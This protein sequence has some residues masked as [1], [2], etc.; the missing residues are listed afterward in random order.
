[1]AHDTPAA[2]ARADRTRALTATRVDR[3]RALTAA[4]LLLGAGAV[5]APAAAQTDYYNLDR[6]RPARIEDAYATERYAF[7]LKVATLRL[8]REAGGVYHWGYEPE[9][10]YGILPRTSVEVGLPFAVIDA[11]A[12][13]R[14]SGLAGLELSVLYNLNAETQGLPALGLR[15]DVLLPVGSLAPDRA[16][17]A[18][19]G[20]MTRSFRWARFHV[21]AQYTFGAA[22]EPAAAPPPD[23]LHGP[24]EEPPRWLAGVAVDHV[25]P[26]RALLLIADVYASQPLHQD[27]A[28]AWDAGVGLRYQVN[29]YLAVDAGLGRRLTGAPAW[30]LTLGSAFAFGLRPFVPVPR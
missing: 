23:G 3:T 10:A 9:L 12:A 7:E 15:G 19:T 17:P 18:L 6:H 26:L 25:F 16:Y 2:A 29:P 30:H 8:E 13:G 5:T 24:A 1:M 4:L 27:D 11:G 14:R 21:N 20:I 22:P 28:V